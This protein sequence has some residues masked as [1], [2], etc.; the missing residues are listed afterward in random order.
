MHP[1]LRTPKQ[2]LMVG[3]LWSPICFWVISLLVSLLDVSWWEASIWA[4]PPMLVELFICLSGWYLCRMTVIHRW[5]LGRTIWTHVVAA[6]LLNGV[7]LF[8]VWLYSEA[9]VM[10]FK[11][12]TWQIHFVNAL[13]VFIA[14]GMSLYF[15][16]ILSHYLVLTI[17]KTKQ[18]EE[19]VLNQKILAGQAELKALKAT[20]HPH[21]LFNC[22]NLLSPLMR[23]SP[24]K[25]QEVVVQLA[26]FL[27]YSLRYGK[28][29]W[30]RVRD[31]VEHVKNYLGIESIRLGERLR[32]EWDIDGDVLDLP[33]LPLVLLP[34]VENAIKHGINHCLEGGTLSLII[35]HEG[36]H[37]FVAI[38]NPHDE[39]A[40]VVQG[41]GLGLETVKQR[42]TA[43]YNDEG[44]LNTW[45]DEKIFRVELRFP[46]T[47][48]G[49]E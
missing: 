10:M 19:E 41:E 47:R 3:L 43:F 42:L 36:S 25:A 45:K 46:Q 32:V 22:L 34:L 6:L 16:A 37:I 12:D 27:L 4:V 21:F 31:E 17:E 29:E 14:V 2:F 24:S 28:Q 35:K 23:S 40:R 7:W 13:P 5:Y 1:F 48:K 18:V 8:L 49:L 44:Q 11:T 33:M 9:M 20:I 38:T 30:V 15:I 39:P 26:D